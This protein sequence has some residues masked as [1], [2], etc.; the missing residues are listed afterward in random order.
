[1]SGQPCTAKTEVWARVV[2][3]FR[4][5]KQW[6]KGQ[7]AQYDARTPYRPGVGAPL[8]APDSDQEG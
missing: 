5:L 6:N 1:M 2:G 7:R 8:A 4:P 3:F